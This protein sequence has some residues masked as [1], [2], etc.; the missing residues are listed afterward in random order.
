MKG[1][2]ET[3]IKQLNLKPHPEGGYFR[4]TYRSTGSFEYFAPD[5]SLVGERNYSTCIYFLLT[6]ETFSAFH[7]IR[8]DETWHFYAGAPLDLH[9]ISPE[10]AYSKVVIGNNIENGELFQFVVPGGYWFAAEVNG[11][12]GFSLLGCTVAPGFDFSDFE[13]AKGNELS[14]D[15]PKHKDTI[16]RLTR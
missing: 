16:L 4:E 11:E 13:L 6:K 8:Q 7:R 10:G 15:F 5:N 12:A 3:Y 9:M 2:I 14:E 1:Q